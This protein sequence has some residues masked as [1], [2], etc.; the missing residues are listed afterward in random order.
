MGIWQRI[1]NLFRSNINAAIDRVADPEKEIEQLIL[2]MEEELLGERKELRDQLAQGKLLEKRV[3][4]SAANLKKLQDHARL[5]VQQ[6]KDDLARDILRRLQEMEIPHQQMLQHYQTQMAAVE[7]STAKLRGN[8]QK[9]YQIKARKESIKAQARMQK[10]QL[11][12]PAGSA[13]DRFDQ[14]AEQI[15]M[16]EHQAAAW[17]EVHALQPQTQYVLSTTTDPVTGHAL[18]DQQQ[19]VSMKDLEVEQRLQ[20][21]KAAAG[22]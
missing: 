3:Q 16:N 1:S 14:L 8:E 15:E 17:N 11:S 10:K 7:Q 12:T 13:F 18:T 2:D 19:P 4:E 22:K 21:L 5:A 20:A 9:F 6:G